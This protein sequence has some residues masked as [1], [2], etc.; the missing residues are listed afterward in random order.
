MKEARSFTLLSVT[1]GLATNALAQLPNGAAIFPR[2]FNDDSDSILTIVNNYP[3]LI[4]FEDRMLDGD[5]MGGEFANRHVWRF[6]QDGGMTAMTFGPSSSFNTSFDVTITADSTITPRKE[7]GFLVDNGDCAVACAGQGQFIVNSDAHEV[8]VFGGG[9]PFFAF[10]PTYDVGETVRL[11]LTYFLDVDGM[12][13]VQYSAQFIN[14]PG[15]LLMSPILTMDNVEHVLLAG[16]RVGGYGQF[17]IQVGNPEN[18]ATAIFGNITFVPEPSSLM[19][20]GFAGLV[21]LRRRRH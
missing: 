13:K 2:E 1:L 14:P 10:P 3:A 11:G 6:S 18:G 15:P 17:N 9:F 8:V 19:L 5:G 21:G 12:G 7:A 20:L 16:S 4:S